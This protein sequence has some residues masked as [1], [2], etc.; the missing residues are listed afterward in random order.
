MNMHVK[1]N[2]RGKDN[3]CSRLSKKVILR[4]HFLRKINSIKPKLPLTLEGTYLRV[5]TLNQ[6]P[7]QK[8]GVRS[9][10][11]FQRARGI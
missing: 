5:Q 7:G 9:T 11:P 10:I 3:H 8:G 2:L 6:L 1:I 4:F